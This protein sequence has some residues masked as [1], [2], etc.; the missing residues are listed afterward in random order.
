MNLYTE[1]SKEDQSIALARERTLL[2]AERTFLSWIQTGLTSMGISLAIARLLIFQTTEAT[3]IARLVE[4]LLILWG[5][6]IF[7]FALINYQRSHQ[8]LTLSMPTL[9]SLTGL[10][11]MTLILIILCSLLFWIVMG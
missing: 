3:H 4:P 7:V 5:V 6:G 10:T 2:A 1:Q 9:H 8:K 11:L